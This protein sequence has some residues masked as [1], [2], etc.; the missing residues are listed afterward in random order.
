MPKVKSKPSKKLID[1]VNEYGSD[2]S[3]TDN[4][5][6]FCK[7]CGKSINHEKKQKVNK[8]S[9]FVANSSS[10][11]QF[12]T[13]LCMAF[14]DAGIPLWKLE[15]KSLRGFLEKY[16]KQH[17]PSESSLRKNYIDNN[18]NNVMDRVRR[19]V[20]YN[21]I[22][23]SID[24][25]IDP[26]GRFVANV[27]IGTL[28][29]DQP[30]KEYEDFICA[31]TRVFYAKRGRRNTQSNNNFNNVMD[32]VRREV[33][34]NKIWISIDETIDPVG[35]F[36][37][38]VVIGTLEADQP[39]KEYLLTSEVLEKSNKK[40]TK[41][42][43]PSESSLRKNYIDNNF[44]NV[45]DRVRREVA[46]NKIWISIDETI[47]PVGRFVANVVIG[48]LEADQPSKEYLLTSEVLKGCFL[49]TSAISAALIY[50]VKINCAVK[51]VYLIF[52][53]SVDFSFTRVLLRLLCRSYP[54]SATSASFKMF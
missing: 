38:N 34:Y 44:N 32:R 46:Y 6:L 51:R 33:A 23:I 42:H 3:S 14:I 13:E 45:M 47:D 16:T 18:F 7:A 24:E 39:S 52:P 17:I 54:R 28:E 25:T 10:K 43:I 19:E 26:V 35:R 27:V 8:L 1:L 9:T 40:Y 49:Y 37:A 22:W 2:I 48:T 5:V 36:V 30:S 41:Q 21:K 29:A 11:S 20:A 50:Q 12:P 4:T 53:Q 15:K 31:R